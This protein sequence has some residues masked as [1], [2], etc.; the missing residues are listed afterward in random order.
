MV[1]K[2]NDMADFGS[3]PERYV[4]SPEQTDLLCRIKPLRVG[5]TTKTRTL[6]KTMSN[7]DFLCD[8]LHFW[9]IS[10]NFSVCGARFQCSISRVLRYSIKTITLEISGWLALEGYRTHHISFQIS[11]KLVAQK[12]DLLLG[13]SDDI[14]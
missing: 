10:T 8:V 6:L 3:L 13:P 12:A 14:R 2:E 1:C 4:D 11:L 9:K 7:L 5:C